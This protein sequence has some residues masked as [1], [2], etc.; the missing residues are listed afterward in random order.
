MSAEPTREAPKSGRSAGDGIRSLILA[1]AGRAVD[2]PAQSRVPLRPLANQGNAGRSG[3]AGARVPPQ[4]G[5]RRRK[6]RKLRH[7]KTARRI[8]GPFFLDGLS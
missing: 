6:S 4:P 2:R 3:V 8:G 7:S 1:R 5:P